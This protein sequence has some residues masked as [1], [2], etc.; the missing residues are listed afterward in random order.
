MIFLNSLAH[1]Q[2][3]HWDNNNI[4]RKGK[5]NLEILDNILG[6]LLKM[7][8]KKESLIILNGLSQK[9]VKSKGYCIYKLKSTKNFLDDFKIKYLEI[10]QC[11]TNDGHIKFNSIKDLKKAKN[12]LDSFLIKNKNYFLL[13]FFP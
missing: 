13:R 3:H 7:I 2:H 5:I 10:E 4:N 12:I 8:D 9:N 1:Y 6:K 11:M